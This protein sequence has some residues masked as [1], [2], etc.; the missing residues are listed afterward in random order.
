MVVKALDRSINRGFVGAIFDLGE[1]IFVS[2]GH[3]AVG[4]GVDLF[5]LS[6]RRL[7]LLRELLV[8]WA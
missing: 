1:H 2:G 5:Q 8:D 4:G 3:L 6:E 7:D